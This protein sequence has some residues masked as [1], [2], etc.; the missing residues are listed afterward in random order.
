[1][2]LVHGQKPSCGRVPSRGTESIGPL[3]GSDLDDHGLGDV[4][5]HR[6]C[7]ACRLFFGAGRAVVHDRRS[8]P[9]EPLRGFFW[10]HF[11]PRWRG[12]GSGAPKGARA[13]K[14]PNDVRHRN[15]RVHERHATCPERICSRHVT[16]L[17][18]RRPSLLTG[19]PFGAPLRHSRSGTCGSRMLACMSVTHDRGKPHPA[20]PSRSSP[21]DL[22]R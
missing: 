10:R 11:V 3:R 12:E 4:H 2:V 19:T 17:S 8:A 7:S 6:Q 13:R 16:T 20:P 15:V 1:M 18:R 5:A 22:P 9:F 14:A 21:E